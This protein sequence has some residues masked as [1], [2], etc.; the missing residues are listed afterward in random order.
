MYSNEVKAKSEGEQKKLESKLKR[1]MKHEAW[2]M[3]NEKWEKCFEKV[4]RIIRRVHNKIIKNIWYAVAVVVGFADSSCWWSWWCCRIEIACVTACISCIVY[5]CQWFGYWHTIFAHNSANVC[6]CVC[7]W[8]VFYIHTARSIVTNVTNGD[9]TITRKLYKLFLYPRPVL[10]TL[11]FSPHTTTSFRYL[12]IYLTLFVL[13]KYVKHVCVRVYVTRYG[14]AY[15][16]I[17]SLLGIILVFIL[18]SV[19]IPNIQQL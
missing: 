13:L 9:E 12:F 11:L 8:S 16:T 5:R 15:Q 18:S 10:F 3:E 1:N 4:N 6:V 19:Y 7:V 17:I 14:Y 2:K